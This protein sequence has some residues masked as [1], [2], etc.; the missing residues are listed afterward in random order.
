MFGRTAWARR[1]PKARAPPVY[2]RGDSVIPLC[3]GVQG[4]FMET[5]QKGDAQAGGPG[6]RGLLLMGTGFQFRRMETSVDRWGWRLR[7]TMSV[8]KA[9]ELDSTVVKMANVICILPQ[10]FLKR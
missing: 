9:T 1:E 4:G 5:E 3:R 8:C 7:N 6:G 10:F 2:S